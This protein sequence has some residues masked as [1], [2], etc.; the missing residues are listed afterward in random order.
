MKQKLFIFTLLFSIILPNNIWAQPSNAISLDN[1]VCYDALPKKK[2]YILEDTTKTLTINDIKSGKFDDKFV[3][4]EQKT[5]Q[6]KTD[7]VYWLRF[8]FTRKKSTASKWIIQH[9]YQFA[10]I[11]AYDFS[12]D[13]KYMTEKSGTFFPNSQRS[14]PRLFAFG[15]KLNLDN[16]NETIYL[17]L[18]NVLE[19]NFKHEF[20][21]FQE[22]NYEYIE[23]WK[24]LIQGIFQGLLWM[25]IIYNLFSYFSQRNTEQLYYIGFMLIISL[26]FLNDYHYL[27]VISDVISTNISYGYWTLQIGF[28]LYLQFARRFIGIEKHFPKANKILSIYIIIAYIFA[29]ISFVL[30]KINQSLY[31]QVS[32]LSYSIFLIIAFWFIYLGAKIKTKITKYFLIGMAGLLLGAFITLLGTTG[33]IRLDL[34]YFQIGLEIPFSVFSF[35]LLVKQ[36][37]ERRAAQQEIIDHLTQ[38]DLLQT[39]VNRE[40]EEKVQE[41]TAQISQKNDEIL[42]QSENL[43]EANYEITQNNKKLNEKNQQITDSITYARRIQKAILGEISEIENAFSDAFV[44]FKPHSIVSGDFYWYKKI[45]SQGKTYKIVIAADCTGHG[46]PGAFMT[47]MGSDFI[48][49]IVTQEKTIMPHKILAELDKKVTK[50]LRGDKNSG[51]INDGMD[52]SILVFEEG[53]NT[54]YFAAAKNPLYYIS[55]G[56]MNIIK[57]TK[58]AIGGIAPP[59]GAEKNFALHKINQQKGDKF[60]IFSDGFQDQFGGKHGR[61]YMTKNYR[62]FLHQISTLPAKAQKEKLETELRTWKKNDEQTDDII[63]IGISST[64]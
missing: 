9:P 23:Y 6:L 5:G 13:T 35:G 25:L 59:K 24:N 60:Y 57:G 52:I 61:K 31:E 44:F 58:F 40:L 12:S 38:N 43:K 8:Q 14:K 28:V 18:E 17:K 62:D 1:L 53:N 19:M 36:E 7:K 15:F 32:N 64:T 41:R 37:T 10:K 4:F 54:V 27:S 3:P 26:F 46:V 34:I 2:I 39:K 30:I 47:V 45:E 51:Q 16:Q 42:A 56:E 55:Q 50:R 48:D 11:T 29:A 20:T 49:E 22:D 33:L 63:I 21:V